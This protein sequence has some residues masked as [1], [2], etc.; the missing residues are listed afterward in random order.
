MLPNVNTSSARS[1]IMQTEG[2]ALNVTARTGIGMTMPDDSALSDEEIARRQCEL[3]RRFLLVND[4][5][6]A[7]FAR[8][9]GVSA[10]NIERYVKGDRIAPRRRD[11]HTTI[12][13][14]LGMPLYGNEGEPGW[15]SNPPIVQVTPLDELMIRAALLHGREQ[16]REP[17][18]RSSQPR[19]TRQ[20]RRR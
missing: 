16:R 10:R 17:G 18:G 7:D 4:L 14:A 12:A 6:A 3:L 15:L 1:V 5:T 9:Y 2:L 20:P 8:R 11:I 13:H 19:S